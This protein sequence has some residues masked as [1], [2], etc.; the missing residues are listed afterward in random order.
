MRSEVRRPPAGDGIT[1]G[2]IVYCRHYGMPARVMRT[3]GPFVHLVRP[4]GLEWR[5]ARTAVG[6]ATAWER[7]QYRALARLQAQRERGLTAG[8]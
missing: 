7:Q 8:K 2:A 5:S 3:D 6:P 4:S 1:A